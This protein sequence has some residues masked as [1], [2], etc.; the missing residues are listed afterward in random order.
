MVRG[1][2]TSVRRVLCAVLLVGGSLIV[3]AQPAAACSCVRAPGPETDRDFFRASRAVFVG[4]VL[5]SELARGGQ[6]TSSA[7]PEVFTFAV[8][9]VRKGEVSAEQ[10]V[11]TENAGASCG[12]EVAV[13][14]RYLV[15]GSDGGQGSGIEPGD[16]QLY[17]GLCGGTRPLDA[18][19]VSDA[20]G[21][22]PEPEPLPATGGLGSRPEEDGGVPVAIWVVG[23]VAAVVIGAVLAGGLGSS[24][25][26]RR[27]SDAARSL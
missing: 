6:V 4:E 9:E 16:G 14:G 7:D 23:A 20:L 12:L 15:F 8:S 26:I 5:G 3:A 18:G 2:L 22:R 19:A 13:G 10:E 27:R 17:A 24:G 25:R 11:V 21:T 1:S